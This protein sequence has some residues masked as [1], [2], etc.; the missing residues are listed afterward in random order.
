MTKSCTACVA[1]TLPYMLL[2]QKRDWIKWPHVSCRL[3]ASPSEAT[4]E[5][6]RGFALPGVKFSN[7]SDAI[8]SSAPPEGCV[9]YKKSHVEILREFLQRSSMHKDCKMP[10]WQIC[11]VLRHETNL[12]IESAGP[13]FRQWVISGQPLREEN[14][15]YPHQ[16]L[17]GS[18]SCPSHKGELALGNASCCCSSSCIACIS[19]SLCMQGKDFATSRKSF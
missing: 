9:G 3:V 7:P 12:N 8:L 6:L 19:V 11:L 14:A 1:L 5:K 17:L 16:N 2:W 13:A 4:E 18:L 15:A 10:Y